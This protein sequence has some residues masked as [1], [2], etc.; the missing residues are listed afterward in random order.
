MFSITSRWIRNGR[1]KK[2][3]KK[4]KHLIYLVLGSNSAVWF[5]GKILHPSF[6]AG[7]FKGQEHGAIN[8][9]K[10]PGRRQWDQS[11]AEGGPRH[12]SRPGSQV[13]HPMS[14][15]T[16]RKITTQSVNSLKLKK[17]PWPMSAETLYHMTSRWPETWWILYSDWSERCRF[18]FYTS[19]SK[20]S[21]GLC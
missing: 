17:S 6:N 10:G 5:D 15:Q 1:R 13:Q 11:D 21:A 2:K 20:G 12:E 3:R 4:K 16:R 14:R 9:S 8:L 19:S 7:M 18:T